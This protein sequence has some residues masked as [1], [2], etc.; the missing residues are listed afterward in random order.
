[1]SNSGNGANGETPNAAHVGVPT[2]VV[3]LDPRTLLVHMKTGDVQIGL[4]QMM[5]DEAQRQL[6]IMRRQA[7][8]IELQGKLAEAQRVA[9]LV[10]SITGKR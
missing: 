5:L 3:T 7:A 2:V 9:G 1:M 8:A 6:D 4:A 10:A